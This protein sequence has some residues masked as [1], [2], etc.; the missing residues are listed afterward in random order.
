[1]AT[2]REGGENH[3]PDALL[4]GHLGTQTFFELFSFERKALMGRRGGGGVE[5]AGRTF[6]KVKPRENSPT[7][8]SCTL[9]LRRSLAMRMVVRSPL[10]ASSARYRW[11]MMRSW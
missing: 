6:L 8:A 11:R 3:S 5:V 4:P 9:S 2:L 10:S 7:N 1:M